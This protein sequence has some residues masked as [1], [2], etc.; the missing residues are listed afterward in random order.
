M[1]VKRGGIIPKVTR[2]IDR[3]ADRRQIPIPTACPVCNGPVGYKDVASKVKNK[4][5]G[6]VETAPQKSKTL[7]C[8]SETCPGQVIKKLELFLTSLNILGIGDETL[9]VLTRTGLVKDPADLYLLTPEALQDLPLGIGKLGE[10]RAVKIVNAIA[11]KTDLTL[12]EFIGALGIPGL[13]K[14]RATRIQQ[15]VPGEMD[16]LGNWLNGTL[17][18]LAERANVPTQAAAFQAGID[19]RRALIEKFINRRLVTLKPPAPPEKPPRPDALSFCITGTLSRPRGDYAKRI[20]EAGH[21][22]KDSVA[23]GL[24][25]LVVADPDNGSTKIMKAKALGITCI[26]EAELE[27]L[28]KS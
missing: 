9:Q 7:F 17:L 2:V 27:K 8:L 19:A 26:N 1:V 16:R 25:Y 4:E 14:Q 5:P 12:A 18:T 11:K 6:A 22:F 24:N 28:L 21:I 10:K 13:K 15:A 23:K 20:T 3:P